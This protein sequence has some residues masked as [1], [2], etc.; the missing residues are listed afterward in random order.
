MK[1]QVGLFVLAALSLTVVSC[2]NTINSSV[3]SSGGTS[4]S[5]SV[6]ETS[7]STSLNSSASE[8]SSSSS[9]S[10]EFSSETSSSSSSPVVVVTYQLKVTGPAKT[11]Y[12]TGEVFKFETIE[13]ALVK[14][15]DGVISEQTKLSRNQYVV[16]VN[17]QTIE[18][19]FTF[20]DAGSVT[21]N[22]ASK[23][24]EEAVGSFTVSAKTY[25][26]LTNASSDYVVLA[27]LPNK[28]L[29]NEIVSFGLTLLPGYYF[30]GTLTI[31]DGANQKVNYTADNYVYTFT[32]PASNVVIAVETGVNDYTI[33][34]DDDF[35]D[36]VVLDEEEATDEDVFSATPGTKLKFQTHESVDYSFTKVFI[37]G[38]EVVKAADEYYHFVMPHHPVHITTDKANRVYS[39]TTNADELALSTCVMYKDEI[40]KAPI[41]SAIKGERVYL[42]F[43]YDVQLVKYDI[44][45]TDAEG[46]SLEVTQVDGED[47]FYFDMISS[48]ITVQITEDNYSLYYGYYVTNKQ[49]KTWNLYQSSNNF[50]SKTYADLN[51]TGFVFES[52][53]R[54]L[55]GAAGFDWSIASDGTSGYITAHVDNTS[56]ST[57]REFYYTPHLILTKFDDTPSATWKD[58]FV[59]TW[60]E[61]TIIK[62]I[63]FNEDDRLI[64]VEG[65]DGS[66]AEKLLVRDDKVYTDF[67][68]YK[69]E[70]KE[71]LAKGED[72]TTESTYYIDSD[73]ISFKVS[74]GEVKQNYNILVNQVD[75]ATATVTNE[76]GTEIA[77]AE[78][79]QKVIVSVEMLPGVD[80]SI[81]IKGIL[82][83]TTSGSQ[84]SA[85]AVAGETNKWSFTMPM[86]AVT[87]NIDLNDPNKYV[88][89]PA[90]GKY[91]GYN[92]YS[93]NSSDIDF[94]TS[95]VNKLRYEI[96]SAGK[97]IQNE[98]TSTDVSYIDSTERGILTVGSR[99]WSYGGGVIAAPYSDS[100]GDSYIA[101]RI[102]DGYTMDDLFVKV[103][104][105]SSP[106]VY[107]V[108]FHFGGQ[109]STGL[110]VADDTYYC[111]VTFSYDGDMDRVGSEGTFHVHLDDTIIYDVINGVASVHA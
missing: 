107:A 80:E 101:V 32:M 64:W 41:T 95:T 18:G 65:E 89:H 74:A 42:S 26:T 68:V 12:E 34:R 109:F 40:T 21:F 36:K 13:V 3:S 7:S 50:Y 81:T 93:R 82:V 52:N 94:S 84:V 23:E 51:S 47:T 56:V 70:A 71:T 53:G 92:I 11:E 61:N 62:A 28:A 2:N 35:I 102:P 19:D 30:V 8:E 46:N 39:I 20:A 111:G 73:T 6:S 69:D 33:A 67:S 105:L 38:V 106:L 54:G 110:F 103:L 59:G 43:A 15:E 77:A 86:S 104:Y 25:Y 79:G 9:S 58:A 99:T 96:T 108:E 48:N 60:D 72:I 29:E 4:I 27:G 97:F 91:V 78:N 57:V 17:N 49:Y 63:A 14:L 10:S 85:T 1:K 24:H 98:S 37:D 31:T 76:S 16:K 22:I 55:K 90:L 87:I 88:G 66:L 45:V 5:S 100:K 83:R 44:V 75:K